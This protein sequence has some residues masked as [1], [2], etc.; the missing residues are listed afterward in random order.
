M[1][2]RWAATPMIV[3]GNPHIPHTRARTR[4]LALSEG[5]T[6]GGRPASTLPLPL[7]NTF[8]REHIS[9]SECARGE[10]YAAA[11]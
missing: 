2:S 9:A 3:C 10:D 8:D 5:S 7:P 4:V 11:E 6:V 1:T